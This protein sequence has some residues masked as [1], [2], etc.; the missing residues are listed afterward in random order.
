MRDSI[1]CI[2]KDKSREEISGITEGFLSE[3]KT[4]D[5]RQELLEALKL[6]RR[7]GYFLLLLT[8]APDIYAHQIG[9]KFGFD[10][11]ISTK[12][13]FKNDKFLGRA[14]GVVCNNREK[15]K[16]LKELIDGGDFDL[17]SSRGYGNEEDAPWLSLLSKATIY[18]EI[19]GGR[20]RSSPSFRLFA[21]AGSFLR[22]L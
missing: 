12:T 18:K 7:K 9:K 17:S 5:F 3:L 14:L 2:L 11:V 10:K 6:E 21:L 4:A 22:Q 20:L 8:G 16:L 15:P 19:Q 13:E 1:L